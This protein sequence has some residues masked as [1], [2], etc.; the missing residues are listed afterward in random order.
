MTHKINHFE[1]DGTHTVDII[2][3]SAIEHFTKNT[4]LPIQYKCSVNVVLC[5]SKDAKPALKIVFWML[6]THRKMYRERLRLR[7]PLN[8]EAFTLCANISLSLTF[9]RYCCIDELF[10]AIFSS[11]LSESEWC[12]AFDGGVCFCV[13]NNFGFTVFPSLAIFMPTHLKFVADL[14]VW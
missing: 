10:P 8:I 7:S 13:L 4:L 12:K 3:Q 9:M 14:F 6:A 1:T 2:I 11:T 5:V